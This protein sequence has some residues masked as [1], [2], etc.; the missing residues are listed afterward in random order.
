MAR[1]VERVAGDLAVARLSYELFKPI[2]IDVLR[3]EVEDLRPGRRV[4]WLQA[5]LHAGDDLLAR[6]VAVCVR[7]AEVDLEP[8][9]EPGAYDP[10]ISPDEVGPYQFPFFRAEVG[11][12]T[13]MELRV[14]R[15][16]I[17]QGY[18]FAWM[19]MR[20]PLVAGEHPSPL[21]RVVI[22]ADSGNG[23]SAAL[24]HERFL[25]INPE[26]TVHLVRPPTGEW[27]GLEARTSAESNG[28]GLAESR[29]FDV[30]GPIGRGAQSLL[31]DRMPGAVR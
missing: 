5:S 17:G 1:A 20:Y 9:R 11:Y 6:A 19:R 22:A 21:Q 29:L 23:V 31:V 3:I 26:L 16:G 14:A 30:N 27:I 24:D 25:F 18:A 10:P 4:R 28:V 15:G 8:T 13:A 2:P 12:H 7:Q